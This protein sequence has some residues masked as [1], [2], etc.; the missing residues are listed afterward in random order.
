MS[1]DKQPRNYS[2]Y[3]QKI[4]QRYYD[5]NDTIQLQRLADLVGEL[6]LAEGKKKD[7]A[8]KGVAEALRRLKLPEA[9]VEHLVNQQNPALI[10]EVVKEL[11]GRK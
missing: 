3:Q 5:N 4:I 2:P 10:A 6:Y 7:K 8:W 9:R 1:G 11:E